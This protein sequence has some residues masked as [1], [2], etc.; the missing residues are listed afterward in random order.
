MF[1][2][3]GQTSTERLAYILDTDNDICYDVTVLLIMGIL[4]VL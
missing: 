3:K 4:Y 2:G 1:I